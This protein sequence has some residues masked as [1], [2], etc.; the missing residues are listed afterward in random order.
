MTDDL[1]RALLSNRRVLVGAVKAAEEELESCRQ[2]CAEIEDL[3]DRARAILEL[4]TRSSFL[5]TRSR[6]LHEAMEA[7]LRAH[8]AGLTAREIAAEVNRRGLYAR[9]D[10]RPLDSIQV[11]SRA[12]AYN[13][14]FM[15]DHG[16]IRLHGTGTQRDDGQP[17][18][19]GG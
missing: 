4:D 15:R 9:R 1:L 7:V 6:T 3:L 13:S 2:R 14:L 5:A 12:T 16:R 11:H 18:T 8:P 17:V 10:H 19:G